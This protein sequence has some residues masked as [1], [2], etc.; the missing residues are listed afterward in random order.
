QRRVHQPRLRHAPRLPARR[1][2][3]RRRLVSRSRRHD[4]AL[5]RRVRV[6]H[7]RWVCDGRRRG[8]VGH[9][10][11]HGRRGDR[12]HEWRRRR[13]RRRVGHRHRRRLRV[14]RREVGVVGVSRGRVGRRH[15]DDARRHRVHRRVRRGH[16]HRVRRRRRRRVSH[17]R[18][19][20]ARRRPCRRGELPPGRGRRNLRKN[21]RPPPPLIRI[22]DQ[23]RHFRR[24]P[25]RAAA[26][27]ERHAD[28]LL[29]RGG[30]IGDGEVCLLFCTH[31]HHDKRA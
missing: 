20:V 3:R 4:A 9:R 24:A 30:D 22:A 16:R 2:H 26:D 10:G 1:R 11:W 27:T 25:S 21:T 28:A 13:R 23:P 15:G 6:R 31:L 18:E 8:G 17:R 5:L 12:V 19:H 29:E 14:Q 7:R